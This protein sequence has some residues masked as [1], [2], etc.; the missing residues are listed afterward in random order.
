[1]ARSRNIKPGFFKNEDLAECDFAARLLFAGLWVLADREG[2]LEDRP[3]RIKGELFAYD[4]VEVEPL[5][6]Q[7]AH[8]G[9][10]ARYEVEGLR[11][12]QVMK[13]SKHQHPHHKEAPSVLPA[14]PGF[15]PE[16]EDDDEKPG[17]SGPSHGSNAQGKPGTS[18]GQALDKGPV[19]GGSNRAD[20]LFSDSLSSD[21]LNPIPDSTKKTS[22]RKPRDLMNEFHDL[23]EGVEPQVL[24]DWT[25][26][27]KSKRSQI[28]RTGLAAIRDEAGKAGM[29]MNA[30][31]AMCCARGWQGFRAEWA[32]GDGRHQGTSTQAIR[33]AGTQA[34]AYP[35]ET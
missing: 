30:A 32:K 25:S 23:L 12:I 22:T 16:A 20:S 33:T 5:L 11:V 2:R 9:F 6:Q 27:R 18:P 10:I 7:L 24:S 31:L 28:T 17:T 15:V 4:S 13:F 14:M 34:N 35:L 26:L 1:M 8:H 19:E 21:S 3:K 29:S